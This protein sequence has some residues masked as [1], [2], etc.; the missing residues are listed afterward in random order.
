ML[1]SSLLLHEY[2]I[3]KSFYRLA[4]R[5]TGWRV[6]RIWECDLAKF[7]E[8]CVRRILEKLKVEG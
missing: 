7:P 1:V 4:L 2:V 6:I 3:G 8:S 5:R